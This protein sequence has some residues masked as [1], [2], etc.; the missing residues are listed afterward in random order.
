MFT[1]TTL[2][3]VFRIVSAKALGVPLVCSS[4]DALKVLLSRWATDFVCTSINSVTALGFDNASFSMFVEVRR[5]ET[6][7][8]SSFDSS[9]ISVIS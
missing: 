8:D 6:T 9:E 7:S 3:E 5:F 1:Y 2:G 4:A